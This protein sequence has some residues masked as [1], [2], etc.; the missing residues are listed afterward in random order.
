[1]SEKLTPAARTRMRNSPGRGTGSGP[2]RI[3]KTSGGPW[4]V[5]TAWRMGRIVAAVRGAECG[6]RIAGCLISMLYTHVAGR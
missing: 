2:S 1:M 5:I 6:M 4:R 3:E